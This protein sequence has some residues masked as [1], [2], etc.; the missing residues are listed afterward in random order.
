MRIK[1][2]NIPWYLDKLSNWKTIHSRG[3]YEGDQEERRLRHWVIVERRESSRKDKSWSIHS[4]GLRSKTRVEL[5]LN[6]EGIKICWWKMLYL[7]P[8][9]RKQRADIQCV[10]NRAQ[11]REWRQN[12]SDQKK[13]FSPLAFCL[14]PNYPNTVAYFEQPPSPMVRTP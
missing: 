7:H 12:F 3:S 5:D 14:F 10:D 1:R 8:R 6:R 9:R 4:V 2:E 11:R 13:G